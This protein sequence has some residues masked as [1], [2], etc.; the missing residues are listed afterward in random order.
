M[1]STAPSLT[2]TYDLDEAGRAQLLVHRKPKE[3][4]FVFSYTYMYMYMYIYIYRY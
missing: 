2:A 4:V 1:D 3:V